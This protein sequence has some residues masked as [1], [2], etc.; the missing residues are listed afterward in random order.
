MQWYSP[1]ASRL[2]YV[3][4]KRLGGICAARGMGHATLLRVG[5]VEAHC[6]RRALSGYAWM[7]W[8]RVSSIV[9]TFA[10]L[11][12]SSLARRILA[13]RMTRVENG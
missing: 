4:P 1:I 2:L 11:V 8:W 13:P 7:T 5:P 12:V 6:A 9:T 10:C 3:Y